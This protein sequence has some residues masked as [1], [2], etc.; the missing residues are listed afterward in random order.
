VRYL[1]GLTPRPRGMCP[2]SPARDGGADAQEENGDGRRLPHVLDGP[3][4]CPGEAGFDTYPLARRN[5]EPLL[6]NL[7]RRGSLGPGLARCNGRRRPLGRLAS[8]RRRRPSAPA[9]C[10]GVGS[11]AGSFAP[12]HV[13]FT[14]RSRF[15]AT[16]RRDA[17]PGTQ[18]RWGWASVSVVGFGWNGCSASIGIGVRLEP[19]FRIH[20]ESGIA[21]VVVSMLRRPAVRLSRWNPDRSVAGEP[22]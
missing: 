10:R 7:G 11:Y 8:R 13:R 21:L 6:P 19:T 20:S 1:L 16:H 3:L 22:L 18:G 9:T 4:A 2:S 17:R 14:A 15:L 5:R 12:D